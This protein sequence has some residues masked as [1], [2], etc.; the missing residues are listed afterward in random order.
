MSSRKGLRPNRPTQ[1]APLRLADRASW[2][3]WAFRAPEQRA[4]E[5]LESASAPRKRWKVWFQVPVTAALA[6]Q[7]HDLILPS[8][9]RLPTCREG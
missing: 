3:I 8:L 1:P 5:A 4:E 2:S 7:F 9:I 6:I